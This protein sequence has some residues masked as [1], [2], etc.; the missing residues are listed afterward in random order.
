MTLDSKLSPISPNGKRTT[1]K[2][3]TKPTQEN[4]TPRSPARR[5]PPERRLHPQQTGAEPEKKKKHKKNG[6]TRTDQE[7]DQPDLNTHQQRTETNRRAQKRTK[8]KKNGER[9][10][11]AAAKQRNRSTATTV[12]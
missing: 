10:T 3:N 4:D 8:T 11:T 12:Q 1:T 2:G 5:E 9:N 6:A 7:T